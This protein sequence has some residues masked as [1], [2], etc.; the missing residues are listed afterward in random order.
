[1]AGVIGAVEFY[2]NSYFEVNNVVV[3]FYSLGYKFTKFFRITV[4]PCIYAIVIEEEF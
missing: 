2:T 4:A 3:I 1:M